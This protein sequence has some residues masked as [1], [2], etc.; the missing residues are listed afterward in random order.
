MSVPN[1]EEI[2]ILDS[3]K[4]LCRL[5]RDGQVVSTYFEEPVQAL[6]AGEEKNQWLAV[7]W[8]SGGLSFGVGAD[9]LKVV[10]LSDRVLGALSLIIS[11]GDMFALD[12]KHGEVLRI[13]LDFGSNNMTVVTVQSNLFLEG[14]SMM[15]MTLDMPYGLYVMDG[16]NQQFIQ[17]ENLGCL[18]PPGYSVFQIESENC[19]PAPVG[20]FVDVLGNFIA[21]N[22]GTYG[23]LGQATA[24]QACQPCPP[25]TI[26]NASQSTFCSPC[27][28]LFTDPSQTRC[29]SACPRGTQTVGLQCIACPMGQTFAGGSC[30]P[31]PA[32]TFTLGYECQP[33]DAGS[34]S[35]IGSSACSLVCQEG[36]CAVDGTSS[37]YVEL[38][39]QNMSVF[40]I[41]VLGVHPIDMVVAR[42]GT[43]YVAA[44]QLLIVVD[45]FAYC[46]S[47]Y[48]L[49]D[50]DIV[51]MQ[52]WEFHTDCFARV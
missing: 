5:G 37:S 23:A 26:S 45:R 1:S 38:S 12:T 21:C 13:S 2:L 4:R 50:E 40:T 31:C 10:H 8:M 7:A 3:G 43:V 48:F 47:F 9:S 32:N 11:N 49:D 6:S 19:Q 22:P 42:N 30:V 25:L 41:A 33:C 35:A 27:F 34:I 36:T 44:F 51:M 18:C 20:G 29:L 16:V 39:P 14:I 28:S 15:T 24:E 17:V 46:N 52:E